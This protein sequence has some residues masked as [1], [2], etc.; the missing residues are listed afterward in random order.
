MRKLFIIAFI[1][2]LPY[3]LLTDEDVIIIT[4]DKIKSMNAQDIVDLLNRL[5]G[6]RAGSNTI[7][8]WG[9]SNVRV[10]LDGRPLNDPLSTIQKIR[11]SAV[12]LSRVERI[13]IYKGGGGVR[14]GEDTGGG[15]INIITKTTSPGFDIKILGGNYR[16][17][18][19]ELNID[20]RLRG[21]SY[22]FTGDMEKTNGYRRNDDRWE[23][24]V[25][26]RVGYRSLSSSIEY[27]SKERGKPGLPKWPTPR[28][29]E[30]S[31]H[32]GFSAN[33][34]FKN[35]KWGLY[36]Q[37]YRKRYKNPDIHLFRNLQG[38]RGRGIIDTLLPKDLKGG[39]S[40]ETLGISGTKIPHK[41]EKRLGMYLEKSI[42]LN[43]FKINLGMRYGIFTGFPSTLN[44]KVSI[45]Y[46]GKKVNLKFSFIKTC[47]LPTLLQRYRET[48]YT[49]PNPNLD[50]ET[51]LNHKLTCS[52][53]LS[54]F[55]INFA[56][57]HNKIEDR[58]TY[59]RKDR[60][61]GSYE[62]LGKVIMKGGEISLKTMLSPSITGNISY[63]Y[64]YAKDLK[65]NLYLPAR[66]M[67]TLKIYVNLHP[68]RCTSIILSGKYVSKQYVRA[69]NKEWVP[70]YFVT[71]LRA[72]FHKKD[73]KL[74]L[75]VDNLF[76][77]KYFYG[78]GYPAPPLTWK[79]GLE[80]SF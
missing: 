10:F 66:P 32:I 55:K 49:K 54:L 57:F 64:L 13:E 73:W 16:T 44:P 68:T 23:L 9:S 69:D 42:P 6:V 56:I 7:S 53:S 8:L 14:F 35:L 30:K 78:D 38:W 58:I 22:G 39:L 19:G 80:L 52:T 48:T 3:R 4:S 62:N 24:S 17:W 29:K 46:Q 67:H 34:S 36:L 5:P 45:S 27:I 72:E 77:K 76:N 65:R 60:G 37:R 33:S 47:N 41:D 31:K 59:V 15:V 43:H 40:I 28:A 71:D 12:H 21:I 79:M 2:I 1:F 25:E 51:S 20:H 63:T 74:L 26:A 75:Y 11:W 61:I 70:S 18:E 50:M